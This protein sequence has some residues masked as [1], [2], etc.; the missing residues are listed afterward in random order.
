MIVRL[1]RGMDYPTALRNCGR[2]GSFGLVAQV[3]WFNTGNPNIDYS[4]EVELKVAKEM[5]AD[6]LDMNSF[7]TEV[8]RYAG[9]AEVVSE[10]GEEV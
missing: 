9:V 1:I 6:M 4:F 7:I 8:L 10:W 3:I 2:A 5:D